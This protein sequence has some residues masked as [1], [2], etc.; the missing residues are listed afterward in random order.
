MNNNHIY[1]SSDGY[2]HPPTSRPLSAGG[3]YSSAAAQSSVATDQGSPGVVATGG[4]IISEVTVN[5]PDLN[6]RPARSAMKG[7][8]GKE[9]FHRQLADKL[10]ER[11][12]AQQLSMEAS[13]IREDAG[14][15]GGSR[16]STLQRSS[17][18][19]M[20]PPTAPKPKSKG[21]RIAEPP[22]T[23]STGDSNKENHHHESYDNVP[24]YDNLHDDDSS[25]EEIRWRDDDETSQSILAAKV[26]RSDSLAKFLSNRPSRRLLEER[27]ILPVASE[28]E[29][30]KEK[31]IISIKLNR[32]L[33]LRPTAADLEAKNILHKQTL[34]EIQREKEEKKKTLI[35]KLSFRPT[36]EELRERKIIRFNDYVE[37][38]ECDIIDRRADKPWTRL[39]PKDKAMI[40]RE[41]NDFKSTEMDVHEDSRHLT[42]F[43]RP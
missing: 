26:Q 31:E 39:T 1:S 8:K 18:G 7:A 11:R 42:R 41:L 25:D 5:E 33:S 40:R 14:D 23:S 37:V 9:M 32:R 36:V 6:K 15:G 16:Q 20:A 13:S 24:D 3:N 43:H 29:R 4:R 27:N 34:D 21:V 2:S 30:E 17:G 38:T 28:K 10:N 22:R 12:L 19:G 35:R